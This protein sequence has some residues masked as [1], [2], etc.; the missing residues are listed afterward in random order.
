MPVSEEEIIYGVLCTI[1]L[2]LVY[3]PKGSKE[4]DMNAAVFEHQKEF[5][6]SFHPKIS[7]TTNQGVVGVVKDSRITEKIIK[8][9]NIVTKESFR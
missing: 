1:C 4:G 2:G 5:G 8:E 9:R 7:G 6:H 3:L